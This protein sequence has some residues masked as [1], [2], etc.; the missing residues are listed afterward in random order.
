MRPKKD[1]AKV[2]KR[3]GFVLMRCKT[4]CIWQHP[5]TGARIVSAASPSDQ[6]SLKNFEHRLRKA[7]AN[8]RWSVQHLTTN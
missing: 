4:H 6:R 5:K 3:Y 1:F 8:P 7:V 2:A